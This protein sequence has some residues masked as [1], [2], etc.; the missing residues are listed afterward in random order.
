M[1]KSKKARVTIILKGFLKG[2]KGRA[3]VK[4]VFSTRE[5]FCVFI[6]IEEIGVHLWIVK[7]KLKPLFHLYWPLKYS[8][9]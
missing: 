4:L 8:T 5:L 9:F 2:E 6:L 7:M 3:I 1:Q